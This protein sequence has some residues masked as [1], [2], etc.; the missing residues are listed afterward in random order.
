MHEHVKYATYKKIDSKQIK[1]VQ[2]ILVF[3]GI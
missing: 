3:P 1:I 2:H